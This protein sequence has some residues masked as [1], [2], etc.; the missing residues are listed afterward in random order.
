[1]SFELDKEQYTKLAA[2]IKEQHVKMVEIQKQDPI[3]AKYISRDADGTEY[4]YLGA[5]GGGC[6]YEFTPT[7]LGTVTKVTWCA[8]TDYEA[9][10]DLTDYDS[11]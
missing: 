1:M 2:F 10:I 6:S 4:P 8:G 5:I 7:G 9:T 11:W 3:T